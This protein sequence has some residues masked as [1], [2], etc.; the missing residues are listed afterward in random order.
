MAS[1]SF[2]HLVPNVDTR[3]IIDLDPQEQGETSKKTT[4]LRNKEA[5]RVH[6]RTRY[7]KRK[8][9]ERY[10]QMKKKCDAK[11]KRSRTCWIEA[12]IMCG[13]SSL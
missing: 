3:A 10:K 11:R 7:L 5:A 12:C 4:R 1:R 2:A 13:V 8:N 6:E 9:T